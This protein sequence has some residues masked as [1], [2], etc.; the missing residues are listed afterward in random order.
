M[1]KSIVIPL[2]T[3]CERCGRNHR[4]VRARLLRRPTGNP[5]DVGLVMACWLTCPR[6]GEP[7]FVTDGDVEYLTTEDV[8]SIRWGAKP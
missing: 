4:N 8:E 6:T 1:K 5:L 2:F 7:Q 3:N